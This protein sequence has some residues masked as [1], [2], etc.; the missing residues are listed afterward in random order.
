MCAGHYLWVTSNKTQGSGSH[1]QSIP[2]SP[3]FESLLTWPPS[4]NFT[5]FPPHPLQH[6]CSHSSPH[7]LR[8]SG[9]KPGVSLSPAHT[10]PISRAYKLCPQ[11]SSPL[12]GR[13]GSRGCIRDSPE[14]L[15]LISRGS[16][17]LRSPL[18]SRRVSSPHSLHHIQPCPRA[19]GLPWGLPGGLPCPGQV[20]LWC[21][22]LAGLIPSVYR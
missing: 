11:H 20:W 5:P 21:C 16:K 2:R 15:G 19:G 22:W 9:Q 4:P 8:S 1:Q 14:E 17:G 12:Q 7:S 18:E 6:C 10:Q 13:Q 3:S